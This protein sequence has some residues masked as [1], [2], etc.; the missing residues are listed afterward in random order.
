MKITS[1]A[2]EA[3][4]NIPSEY[5]CDGADQSPPL[6]IKEVPLTAKSLALIVDDP[7]AP[8]KSSNW[9]CL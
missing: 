8:G 1:P 6:K 3:E 5:T 9:D 7:G 4:G 2:F